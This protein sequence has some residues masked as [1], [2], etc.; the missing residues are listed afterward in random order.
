MVMNT[1]KMFMTV[2][3][4]THNNRQ[5]STI[6]ILFHGNT[7]PIQLLAVGGNMG[8]IIMYYYLCVVL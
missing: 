8:F 3:N 1:E 4:D 5:F 6:P 7:A 2:L